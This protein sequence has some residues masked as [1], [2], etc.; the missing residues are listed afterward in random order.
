[1]PLT[2]ELIVECLSLLCKTGDG[3]AHAYVKL[4]ASGRFDYCYVTSEP[5]LP[6]GGRLD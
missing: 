1:M 6:L 3:M 2:A 5:V 4:D